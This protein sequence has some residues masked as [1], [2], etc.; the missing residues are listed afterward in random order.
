MCDMK[1]S[2]QRMIC[3]LLGSALLA[4]QAAA[5]PIGELK[6]NNRSNYQASS[7]LQTIYD[8]KVENME[9]PL[10]IDSSKPVFSWKL[11]LSGY[12]RAQSAYQLVIASTVQK[13][14]AH[15]GDIWDSAKTLSEKNVDVAYNGSAL[16]SKTKYYWSVQTWDETGASLGWSDVSTFETG[17]LSASDWTAKWISTNKVLTLSNAK[18]IWNRRGMGASSV[19][20]ET[21]YFR[22]TFTPDP[23]K[24]VDSVYLGLSG[25]DYAII[26]LNGEKVAES[27]N[28]TDSWKTGTLVDITNKMTNGANIIAASATNTSAGYAGL[29]SKIQINYKDNTTD[30]IVTDESWLTSLGVSQGWQNAGY[31]TNGWVAP[32][33]AVAYGGAP[34]NSNVN[35]PTSPKTDENSAPIFRK[36]FS[37]SKQIK[38]ARAYICGLGLFE[39]KIN[40]TLADDSVLNPAHTQYDK[41]VFYRVFDVT[42]LLSQGKNAIAVELGNSFFNSD[43]GMWNWNSGVWKSNPKLLMEVSIEYADGTTEKIITDESWKMC[44]NGPTTYNSIYFGEIYDANKE[45]TGYDKPDYDESN[46]K[47]ATATTAPSGTLKFQNMEPIKRQESYT[48]EVKKLSNGDYL[49][50][51]PVMTSG[52]AKIKFNAP[53]GTHITI[54][55]GEKLDYAGSLLKPIRTDWFADTLQEDEYYC[56]GVQ[57]ETYEPKFSYKGYQY[58]LV[59]GYTG[60]LTSSAVTTYSIYNDVDKIAQFETSDDLINTMHENM[61]RTI[62]NNFQGKPT[63]TPLWEKNGWTGDV[64]IAIQTMAYNFDINLFMSKFMDDMEDGQTSSGI[65]GDIAPNAD[66]GVQNNPVWS[67]VYIFGVYELYKYFGNTSIVSEQYDSMKKYMAHTT[68][69]LQNNNWT[70]RED[71]RG[72]WVSPSGGSDPNVSGNDAASEGSGIVASGY[73]Y[74]AYG[75]MAEMAELMGKTTEAAEYKATRQKIKTAFNTKFYN[76]QKKIYETTV[77]NQKGTRTKYRQTSNI[78]PLFLGLVEEQNKQAVLDN[79]VAD[80][81]QK[82]YHLDVGFVG[83]RWILPVLTDNG[84]EDIAYKIVTQTTYPSWGY[85]IEQG[86]TST[87]EAYEKTSRSYNHYFLGTYDE[88]FYKYL[89]GIKDIEQGYKS[90]TIN[91]TVFGELSFVNTSIE[92]PKGTL[93]NN[94]RF[95][96]G[97]TITAEITVPVGS[98]ANI[99]FPTSNLNLV[100]IGGN[101]VTDAT[102]GV[103]SIEAVGKQVKVVAQSG[104][105]VFV[106]DTANIPIYRTE[107]FNVLE[108]ANAVAEVDYDASAWKEFVI[109]RTKAKTVLDNRES[110]QIQINAVKKELED[111]LTAL[112]EHINQ[113]R[114]QLKTLIKEIQDYG[115]KS[116]NYVY[117]AWYD[118]NAQLTSAKT[119]STN[120]SSSQELL[121]QTYGKLNSALKQISRFRI[122]NLALTKQV[123]ASSSAEKPNYNWAKTNINDGDKKNTNSSGE[124][125]GWSSDSSTAVDHEEWVSI[126]LGMKSRFDNVT[127]YPSTSTPL[128]ANSCYGFPKSF[129]I[130]TSVDGQNWEVAYQKTNYEIPGYGAINFKIGEKYA[131]YIKFVGKSLNPKPTDN[132]M[133]RMQ[134]CEIEVY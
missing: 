84:Y 63:D 65:V 79:L 86:A 81:K 64:N 30:T 9:N 31:S 51:N 100:K 133:Y 80:I 77:W 38:S 10:G 3:L 22:K 71:M 128:V 82:G 96:E 5:I 49:I 114:A 21:M 16:T 62:L 106:S 46:W 58:I 26:Y 76:S 2:I 88:W 108:N 131:R 36:E 121:T 52:W 61:Q 8:L 122:G 91:P 19:P 97:N 120:V 11:N 113:A 13:A 1:K 35:L 102:P 109:V 89:A 59:S 73:A 47:S 68:T 55:Y 134:I 117:S 107:L 126:D 40:G 42:S 6:E 53:K 4:S 103:V 50:K 74:Y 110:T 48:P 90:F 125:C 101:A 18:W 54:T 32:D 44:Q 12:A 124:Y 27:G 129:E 34:W 37:A 20:A 25:D 56:K 41:T 66:W 14:S 23:S 111:A 39:L 132:N 43:T 95:S 17:M 87:W 83:T 115:M 105:Y 7:D 92:T 60:N 118:F 93:K 57:N 29:I 85:W 28:Y 67:S 15:Q 45:K 72:D 99:Y 33:Q 98:T 130:L 94:W 104:T 24:V 112:E 119:V 70:W 127:I 69:E 123:T 75:A 78:V 116:S